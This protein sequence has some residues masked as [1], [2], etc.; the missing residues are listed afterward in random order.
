ME[1]SK[2]LVCINDN[3]HSRVALHFACRKAHHTGCPVEM[4]YV[5]EPVEYQ[6]FFPVADVIRAESRAQAESL[7]SRFAEEAYNY[8]GITPSLMVREGILEEEIVATIQ[9]DHSIN[10][11]LLG[12]APDSHSRNNL[13]PRL[14]SQLGKTLQIPMLIIPGNLT[15]Q[16]INELT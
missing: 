6:N 11:L 2:L 14:A 9:E 8:A 3:T 12:T 15:E 4:L 16:Q 5:I 7:L 10:M 1:K 13:L